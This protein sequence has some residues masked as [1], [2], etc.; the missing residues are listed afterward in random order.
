MKTSK[1]FEQPWRDPA[2]VTYLEDALSRR[3]LFMDGAMGTMIQ[4][5]KLSEEDFRGQRYGQHD[6]PLKGNND[7]LALTQ[8]EAIRDIHRSFLAAGAD[9]I[10][11]NTFNANPAA[12]VFPAPAIPANTN[13]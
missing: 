9:L 1:A 7:I 5:M 8:P 2:G 12:V 11:T 10:D 4:D 3:I 13:A 6:H